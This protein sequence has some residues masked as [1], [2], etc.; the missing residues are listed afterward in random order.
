MKRWVSLILALL[1]LLPGFSRGEDLSFL[2]LSVGSKGNG[3]TQLKNRLYELGYFKT[4]N[5]NKKY[6]E[7]TAK[8][9]REFQEANGLPATGETDAETWARLFSD[10]AVR[11]PHPTLLPL[12]TPA[13]TPVPDWP[14]RDAEGFLA[15]EGEYFYEND[16]EGLWIYLGQ[17]LKVVITRRVDS[18]IPLEWFETE[19]WTRNG[20]A[21]RTVVTDPD[22]PG[23]K[24][25][26]PF[27]IARE[28]KAVLAFSDDFYANRIQQKETVGIIVREGRLISSKTNKKAGHHLPNLDMMAQF[29]DGTLQVYQCNE[30]TAE[31]L[32]AMGAR[33]VFSFGP[34][35]LRDGEINELVYTYYKSIEPR[36][37]LGMIEP[38]HYFLLSAQGR[39]SDSKGTTLQRMAEIMKEHGVTQ[40]LN[41]DGGNTMALV[42]RGRMLNKLAVYKDRKFVR[43]VTSVIALGTTDNQAED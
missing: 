7:D 33:N 10:Q 4:A 43:T 8:V 24:L 32:L 35:L 31:E 18:S 38:N 39:N 19:I 41:L 17:N 27:V 29:P 16:E 34:I 30:Y 21:F 6:T 15:R 40:A 9:V 13:P 12:A 25:Q 11:K 23:R 14:E 3:V 22:H 26:Y 1:L 42:F 20:E 28:A 37:A 2:P 36:H 5:F